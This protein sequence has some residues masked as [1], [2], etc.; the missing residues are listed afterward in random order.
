[1]VEYE[2][3]RN[4][5][6]KGIYRSGSKNRKF[7]AISLLEIERFENSRIQKHTS[8]LVCILAIT[9]SGLN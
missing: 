1:M 7:S 6:K 2:D 9:D 3:N 5:A 4:K 8:V